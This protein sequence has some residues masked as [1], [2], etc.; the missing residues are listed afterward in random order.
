MIN[1]FSRIHV[2]DMSGESSLRELRDHSEEA[3]ELL[4]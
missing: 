4:F 1:Y 2:V 3:F